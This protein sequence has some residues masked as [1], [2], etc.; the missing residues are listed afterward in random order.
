MGS[1]TLEIPDDILDE[2]RIPASERASVLRRELS[3]QL[4][5]RDIL[6]KAAARR[7]SGMD[8]LSFDDLLAQRGIVSRLTAD[9]L[10]ADLSSLA[11]LGERAD[12][13]DDVTK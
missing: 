8:R 12:T 3:I 4:Y 6:P 5:A 13:S 1:F 9:D 11:A 10:E 2:A 7:L